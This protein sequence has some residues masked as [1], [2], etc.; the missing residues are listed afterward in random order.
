MPRRP[1]RRRPHPT[2]SVARPARG[3]GRPAERGAPCPR[4]GRR[5]PRAAPEQSP[6]AVALPPR[7]GP[8]AVPAPGRTSGLQAGRHAAA[9]AAWPPPLPPT[10]ARSAPAGTGLV[11]LD[12]DRRERAGHGGGDL[13]VD[14]V[15]GDLEEGL[16]DG[17]LLADLLQPP[18]HGALGDG[19]AERRHRH[20]RAAARATGPR[21]VCCRRLV[22]G[23]LGCCGGLRLLGRC[24]AL[25]GCLGLGG[26]LSL[27]GCLRLRRLLTALVA[28]LGDGVA[29]GRVGHR[30]ARSLRGRCLLALLLTTGP[31]TVGGG[32]VADHREVGADRHGVVLLDEDLLQRPCHRGRDLGVD[33]VGRDL[34][35]RLVD[36]HAVAHTLQPPRHG[37]LGDG[38]AERRHLHA[39]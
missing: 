21:G 25:G 34:E 17:D 10:T 15:R 37:S 28:R 8:A 33:L 30:V 6:P 11:L 18:R 13:G 5:V 38:L 7:R 19:L 14:L 29:V 32:R 23:R 9:A 39:F 20:G 27:C 35:Q 3:P 4:R 2:M 31:T 12:E 22:G 1:C 16:V 36:L 24:L 26:C